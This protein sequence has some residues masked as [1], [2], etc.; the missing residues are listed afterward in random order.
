M[1]ALRRLR[2][3]IKLSQSEFAAQLG[4][5]EQTYRT[6]DSGRRRPP[7]AIVYLARRF[8]ETEGGKLQPRRAPGS[9]ERCHGRGI[10]AIREPRTRRQ[11]IERW[12][13]TLKARRLSGPRWTV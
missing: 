11:S 10:A 9:R 13:C 5:A 3:E 7:C 6:W 2:L 4:V 8:K 12:P 1:N